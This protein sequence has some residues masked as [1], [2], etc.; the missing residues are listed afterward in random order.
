MNLYARRHES[1]FWRN[2]CARTL[3]AV[4]LVLVLVGCGA[5]V[6]APPLAPPTALPQP[7]TP[8]AQVTQQGKALAGTLITTAGYAYADAD[9][10]RLLDAISFSAGATPAPLTPPPQQLWLA[11]SPSASLDQVLRA[12]GNARVATVR[13]RGM[14]SEPGQFGSQGAFVYQLEQPQFELLVPQDVTFKALFADDQKYQYQLIRIVGTLFAQGD[15]GL[16]VEKTDANGVPAPGARQVKLGAPITDTALLA[17][18]QQ[19]RDE[20]VHFGA[21]QVEGFWRDGVIVPLA[22]LPAS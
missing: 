6:P 10:A 19:A 4:V 20:S 15:A 9:G 13:V 12:A 7:F 22:I 1:V 8:L 21:V 2:T 3:G 16:L 18:L 5:T 17:Q 14:L 11:A